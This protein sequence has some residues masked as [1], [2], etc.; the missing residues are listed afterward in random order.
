VLKL[1]NDVV[2]HRLGIALRRYQEYVAGEILNHL[3]RGVQLHS[4]LN[5]YG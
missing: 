3:A 4:Y 2:T 1:F 5:A